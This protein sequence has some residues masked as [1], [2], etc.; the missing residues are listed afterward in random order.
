MQ[1]LAYSILFWEIF[2]NWNYI[3]LKTKQ[4]SPF[5]PKEQLHCF[6]IQTFC[7]FIYFIF[8]LKIRRM[9]VGVC[10]IVSSHCMTMW[11]EKA[12]NTYAEVAPWLQ[13][14]GVRGKSTDMI[15]LFAC[16]FEKNGEQERAIKR[17]NKN[18][19]RCRM[20]KILR[21]GWSISYTDFQVFSSREIPL[22][23]HQINTD[24]HVSKMPH[25]QMQTQK[26]S[27]TGNRRRTYREITDIQ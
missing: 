2:A 23:F 25:R 14:G 11:D 10:V 9:C 22:F 13:E 27:M 19:T 16:L 12:I 7:F 4:K 21:T 26:A 6:S 8:G 15:K 3:F 24:T 20:W 1:I 18:S 5:F 17:Y